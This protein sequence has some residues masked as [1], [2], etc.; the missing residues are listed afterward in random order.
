MRKHRILV[1]DDQAIFREPILTALTASGYQVI[2]A[3]SGFDAIELLKQHATPFD[4]I[5]LD[6]S[7]PSMN[8]LTFLEKLRKSPWSDT[9][10]VML[11]S[12]AEKELVV[13]AGSLG[14]RDYVLK[15]TF[16]MDELLKIIAKYI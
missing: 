5:L 11:T 10:V 8:G 4:L 14:V 3:E 13:A 16:S 6:F 9:Q 12:L 2:G 1:V 15:S 7:M